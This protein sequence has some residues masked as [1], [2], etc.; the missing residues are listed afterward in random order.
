MTYL[1]VMAAFLAG[2]FDDVFLFLVGILVGVLVVLV[3]YTG[4]VTKLARA[5]LELLGE[6]NAE[7]DRVKVL[8]QELEEE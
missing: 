4:R 5:L 6:L 3:I 1:N 8:R 2:P 7:L